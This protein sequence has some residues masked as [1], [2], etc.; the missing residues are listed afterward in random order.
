MFEEYDDVLDHKR[1]QGRKIRNLTCWMEEKT[2]KE[3]VVR[4][5]VKNELFTSLNGAV[6]MEARW[7]SRYHWNKN[8]KLLSEVNKIPARRAWTEFFGCVS[9]ARIVL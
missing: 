4:L 2:N 6:A 3:I 5:E 9:D 1:Q 8:M 7:S